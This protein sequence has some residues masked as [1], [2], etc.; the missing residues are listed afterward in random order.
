MY[1]AI[2]F[3]QS[4]NYLLLGILAGVSHFRP[5]L[6][7]DIPESSLQPD[8]V[9]VHYMNQYCVTQKR[10]HLGFCVSALVEAL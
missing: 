10:G 1:I 9:P 8:V 4:Y 3:M 7:A 6:R 5:E 2:I